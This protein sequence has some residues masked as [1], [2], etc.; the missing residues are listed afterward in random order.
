MSS[1]EIINDKNHKACILKDQ[2]LYKIFGV[3]NQTDT[4]KLE[5]IKK[6]GDEPKE[7]FYYK[8]KEVLSNGKYGKPIYIYKKYL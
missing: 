4:D 3:R 5:H 1:W 7:G 6:Y 8:V 2:K